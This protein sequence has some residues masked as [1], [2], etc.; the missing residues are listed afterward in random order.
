MLR[1]SFEKTVGGLMQG[2]LDLK[3]L[4][5][6]NPVDSSVVFYCYV[7]FIVNMVVEFLTLL[8]RIFVGPRNAEILSLA[9]FNTMD[10]LTLTFMIK[11]V[12]SV[13]S[14]IDEF[15]LDPLSRP[16]FEVV[17]NNQHFL[18]SVI[19]ISL[20]TRILYLIVTFSVLNSIKGQVLQISE[21]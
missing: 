6:K 8:K 1:I 14:A 17:F 19:S 3:Q 7:V 11:V 2:Q 21:E 15:Q 9:L 13:T 5:Y 12:R 4:V 18:I 20:F 16:N 10:A